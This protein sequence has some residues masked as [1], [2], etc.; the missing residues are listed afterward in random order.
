MSISDWVMVGATVVTAVA[1]GVIAFFTWKMHQVT[2]QHSR[3]EEEFR[4]QL[5]DL[6]QA[7]TIATLL[8]GNSNAGV[9]RNAIEAFK[10]VYKGTTPIFR[11][12]R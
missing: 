10:S 4:Q 5:S 11:E 3:K 7:I 12:N 1:T 2:Q 8:S 6:Y 9:L